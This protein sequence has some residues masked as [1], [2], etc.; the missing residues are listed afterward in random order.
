MGLGGNG[1]IPA[2]YS[3]R[4]RPVSYTHLDVYKRQLLGM[5]FHTMQLMT[6]GTDEKERI[7]IRKFLDAGMILLLRTTPEGIGMAENLIGEQDRIF[8]FAGSCREK[9]EFSNCLKQIK[10]WASSLL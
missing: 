10:Q 8:S 2:V 6:E 9:E 7:Y 4:I 1:T 3:D 5:G